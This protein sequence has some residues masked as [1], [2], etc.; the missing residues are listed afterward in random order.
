M[1]WTM[2]SPRKPCAAI[3]IVAH[4][5]ALF[6]PQGLSPPLSYM[7]K[8]LVDHVGVLFGQIALLGYIRG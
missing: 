4:G 5:V 7:R 8:Q 3:W 6:Y 2:P 1:Q